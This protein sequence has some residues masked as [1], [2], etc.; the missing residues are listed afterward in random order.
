[1]FNDDHKLTQRMAPM[2]QK[3]LVVDPSPA[4]ARMLG[5]LMRNLSS[6]QIYTAATNAK[7]IVAAQQVDPQ[8][9]FVELSGDGIDGVAFAREVR[10]SHFNCRE[11]PIIVVTATATAGGIMAAR[12][13]GVHEFLRKPYNAKDLLKRLE[14]VTLRKRDW[15]EAVGYIGPDRRRFNSGDY[16]GPRKRQSDAKTPDAAKIL[17]ALKIVKSAILAID[18]DPAQA[19]RALKAQAADLQKVAQ[20]V[21][22]AT[23]AAAAADFHIYLVG[24]TE[25]GVMRPSEALTR[26][27]PLLALLPKDEPA[28][29]QQAK[30]G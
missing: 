1:V 15:I 29:A 16:T 24:V 20:A 9:I 23:L 22:D 21:G 26:A 7:G 5:D 13:A 14:A 6:G 12:D 3:V 4:S 10:R 17:Q 8:L 27:G 25:L 11:V 18:T 19:L 2:L 30:A 28:R